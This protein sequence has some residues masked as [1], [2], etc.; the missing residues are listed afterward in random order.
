MKY[1]HN[2]SP[3]LEQ[4]TKLSTYFMLFLVQTV[5]AHLCNY[6][7]QFSP[8]LNN[9]RTDE[10]Y[11]IP[12]ILAGT[13]FLPFFIILE[14]IFLL[15]NYLFLKYLLSCKISKVIIFPVFHWQM[16]SPWKGTIWPLDCIHTKGRLKHLLW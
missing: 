9:T 14:M 3:F 15:K 1:T 5:P 16:N 12:L 11:Q 4:Y 10:M 2:F 8:Y 13:F 6:I 7:I